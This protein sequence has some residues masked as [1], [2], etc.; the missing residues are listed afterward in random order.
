M[1]GTLY[2]RVRG[3][4]AGVLGRDQLL[5]HRWIGDHPAQPQAS[6]DELGERAQVDD[7]ASVVL[8][9]ERRR[10]RVAVQMNEACRVV[11]DHRQ[12]VTGGD[13][14]QG[15][16]FFRAEAAASRVLVR[17]HAVQQLGMVAL[18]E[19]RQCFDAQ[20]VG[21]DRHADNAC[22]AGAKR[23]E[24]AQKTGLLDENRVARADEHLGGQVDALLAAAGH[25]YR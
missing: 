25:A 10:R 7:V 22:A 8:G 18:N 16:A 11:L 24:R 4:V 19:G 15:T 17:R 20:T 2:E 1:H 5:E 23:L 21:F 14:Q 9:F 6:R 13:A 3:Q 12:V